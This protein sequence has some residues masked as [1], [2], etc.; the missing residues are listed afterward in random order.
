MDPLLRRRALLLGAA[1]ALTGCGGEP[2]DSPPT[3]I[4]RVRVPLGDPARLRWAEQVDH[5]LLPLPPGARWTYQARA[6]RGPASARARVAGTESVAGLPATELVLTWGDRVE[7]ELYAQDTD[8]NVWLVGVD[9]TD[10]S[11]R[12]GTAGARAGLMLPAAP[13]LGD[14]YSVEPDGP[15]ATRAATTG[16]DEQVTAPLGVLDDAVTLSLTRESGSWTQTRTY[17]PGVGLAL[18]VTI[19]DGTALDLAV[20]EVEGLAG[21]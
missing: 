18:C 5:P 14:G 7:R 20:S 3:G 10:S 1:A 11:W 13:R 21:Q 9:R 17:A 8:G 15:G 16:V 12:L 2:E 6:D 19:T 4:D